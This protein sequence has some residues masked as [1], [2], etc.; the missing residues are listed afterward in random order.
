M[1]VEALS[2]K[3]TSSSLFSLISSTSFSELPI[4]VK[5]KDPKR[6][7]KEDIDLA[8]LSADKD[9][10]QV[11]ASV[12]EILANSQDGGGMSTETDKAMPMEKAFSDS[13][14]AMASKK[15]SKQYQPLSEMVEASG[16]FYSSLTVEQVKNNPEQ[17]LLKIGLRDMSLLNFLCNKISLMAFFHS[18][19]YIYY[20]QFGNLTYNFALISANFVLDALRLL[21]L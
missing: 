2:V 10:A 5:G 13:D 19:L 7:T 20:Y 15:L 18:Q 3:E 6:V 21:V 8:M 1:S 11:T 14:A 17:T 16:G 12:L 4:V 9:L